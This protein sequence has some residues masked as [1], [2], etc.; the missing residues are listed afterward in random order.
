MRDIKYIIIKNPGGI[1]TEIDYNKSKHIPKGV[2]L[3]NRKVGFNECI[4][5]L[6]HFMKKVASINYGD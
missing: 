6:N 1:Q 5:E 2:E 4:M 3:P